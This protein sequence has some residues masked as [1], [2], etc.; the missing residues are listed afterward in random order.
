MV[1]IYGRA[2]WATSGNR[3]VTYH[4]F[5]T[6]TE[7]DDWVSGGSDY[8]NEPGYREAV[9]V[10]DAE[11]R[12]KLDRAR[13]EMEREY[14]PSLGDPTMIAAA[15]GIWPVLTPEDYERGQEARDAAGV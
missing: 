6:R 4:I 9:A 10:S 8:S 1:W 7:R 12:G 2:T 15:A 14:S 3:A 5:D 13:R 11:L